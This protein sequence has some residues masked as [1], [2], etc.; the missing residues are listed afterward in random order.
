MTLVLVYKSAV[1]VTA[2]GLCQ[3]VWKKLKLRYV[4]RYM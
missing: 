4:I 3:F 1:T 2:I